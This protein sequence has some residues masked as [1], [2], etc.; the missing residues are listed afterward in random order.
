MEE[1]ESQYDKDLAEIIAED[2]A[3]G[4]RIRDPRTGALL[5]PSGAIWD[6]GLC[7]PPLHPYGEKANLQRV[8]RYWRL[9]ERAATREFDRLV[10]R[11]R[12]RWPDEALASRLR[13][14]LREA[15]A[16]LAKAAGAEHELLSLRE[17]ALNR[18]TR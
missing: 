1:R 18:R 13:S 7:G 4:P 5:F 6:E 14:L 9:R 2:E 12:A 10:A 11:H 16:A 3:E 15:R 17:H 8:R